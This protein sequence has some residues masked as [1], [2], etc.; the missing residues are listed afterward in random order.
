MS[1][2]FNFCAGP[3]ML[4]QPVMIKAQQEFLNWQNTGSSV[5]EL[6]HRSGIYMTMAKKAELDLRRLMAVPDNYHVLFCH[7]GGR[8]QD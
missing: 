6:S 7:G 8:G 1:D 3:A 4:P 2:I 5:M